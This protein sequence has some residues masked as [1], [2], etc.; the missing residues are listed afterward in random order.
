MTQK[1]KLSRNNQGHK[2]ANIFLVHQSEKPISLDCSYDLILAIDSMQ[3]LSK[4]Q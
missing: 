1:L 3:S 4:Y 2:N